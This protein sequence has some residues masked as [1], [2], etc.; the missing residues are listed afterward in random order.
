[1][2]FTRA[3]RFRM[4]KTI[5][6]IAWPKVGKSVFITLTYPD[7][8]AMH[9]YQERTSHRNRFIRAAEEEHG[10]PIPFLWRVEYTPRKTG[11][12]AG[13]LC[14][15][16]HLLGLGCPFLAKV[17]VNATWR[18]IVHHG[19]A[20]HTRVDG[21]NSGEHAAKYAAKYSAK[22]FLDGLA[23]D[24][25]LDWPPGRAWG[26]TRRHLVP[27]GEEREIELDDEEQIGRAKNLAAEIFGDN[28]LRTFS[29]LDSEAADYFNRIAGMS[30]T[31][32]DGDPAEE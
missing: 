2:G 12:H 5:A 22:E 8:V 25:Y 32:I 27:F 23:N 19:T 21:C 15:H 3:A 20:V 16:M 31:G 13:K 7:P 30:G 4:L 1:M 11:R 6:R 29:V 14:A 24:A 9:S 26:L 10:G 18:G 28:R 17:M